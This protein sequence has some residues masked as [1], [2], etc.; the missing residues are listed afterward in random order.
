MCMAIK[1]L[2]TEDLRASASSLADPE[3]SHGVVHSCLGQ[4]TVLWLAYQSRQVGPCPRKFPVL[5]QQLLRCLK[6]RCAS[7]LPKCVLESHLS[8][9]GYL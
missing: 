7:E 4:R 1:T 3:S 8:R 6:C 9:S 5:R 2:R